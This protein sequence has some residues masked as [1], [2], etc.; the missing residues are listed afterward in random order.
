MD[1]VFY[2]PHDPSQPVNFSS[3]SSFTSSSYELNDSISQSMS[4]SSSYASNRL[5]SQNIPS[6]S[7]SEAGRSQNTSTAFSYASDRLISQNISCPSVSEVS[8][9]LE[10]IS[11][12]RLSSNL[13][14]P[15]INYNAAEIVVDGIPVSIN[16]GF[17]A[18]NNSFFREIFKKYGRPSY[19]LSDLLP[20]GKVGY[21]AFQFFLSYL[22]TGELHPPPL[23]VSTCVD[24]ECAHEACRPAIDLT[25][26]LMYASSI[27]N[28]PELVVDFQGRLVNFVDKAYVED[29]I[30]ILLAAF[31]CQSDDLVNQCVG[32]I[33]RSD[34]DSISIEKELPYELSKTI[35]H[36]REKP[37]SDDEQVSEAVEPVHKKAIRK[38]QQALDWDDIE[39]VY[40]LLHESN[41]TL[42][43]AN[44]LHYAVAYCDSKFVWEL[45]HLGYADVNHRNSQGYTPLHIA[46]MRRE[47][48]IIVSLLL[49]GASASDLTFDGRSALSICRR[50]TS[51]KNYN[52]ETEQGQ[53]TNK[54]RLCID[55]L[56]REMPRNPIT[57]QDAADDT[58]DLNL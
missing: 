9:S 38:I 42:D 27:F 41:V 39:L 50:L 18:E 47:P 15:L 36:S 3:S 40:L 30:P 25:V 54:D 16:G 21:E 34:L 37:M 28:L 32:R 4:I 23:E 48:L 11:L 26:D 2:F 51:I 13:E 44:S 8:P 20:F 58:F 43:D 12:P 5:T 7:G 10:L 56:E 57:S 14:Q 24:E 53:V 52:A 49:K 55:I 6:F 45:L 31:H 17:L 1:D 46:A 22:Y 33:A 29:V 35:E 19:L